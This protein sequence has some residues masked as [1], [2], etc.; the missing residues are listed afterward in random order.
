MIIVSDEILGWW[1][2]FGSDSSWKIWQV[3]PKVSV[4]LFATLISTDAKWLKKTEKT[5]W[6]WAKF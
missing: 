2:G 1:A 6:I 5:P 4:D 3:P